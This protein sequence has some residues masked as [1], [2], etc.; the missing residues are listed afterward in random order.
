MR[1]TLNPGDYVVAS[2]GRTPGRGDI[3]VFEHP[4]RSGFEVVKRVVAVEDSA[5][6]MTAAVA[7]GLR[8][9]VIPNELTAGSD[10]GPAHKVLNH[11]DDAVTEILRLV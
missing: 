7:A 2:T 4:D 10:F 5:R 9:L 8:C 3:V 6:G 11:I 1:P